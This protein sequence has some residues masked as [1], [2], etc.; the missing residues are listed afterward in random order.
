MDLHVSL[1][2]SHPIK[3]VNFPN[4][5]KLVPL[6]MEAIVPKNSMVHWVNIVLMDNSMVR[7]DSNTVRE[8]ITVTCSMEWEIMITLL[9]G[10]V[11]TL[12]T[13]V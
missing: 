10:T 5:V 8:A 12:V 3:L 9:V 1:N 2:S 6:I 4:L 7:I 11:T 13:L